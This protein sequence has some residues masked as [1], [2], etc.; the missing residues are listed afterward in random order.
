MK[1]I[2]KQIVSTLQQLTQFV[3][4]A[5][6]SYEQAAK[7]TQ[8]PPLQRLYRL[9]LSQRAEF[10]SELNQIIQ[11]HHGAVETGT[12]DNSSLY[13]QW[14]DFKADC[15]T[16][17]ETSLIDLNLFGEEWA[18]KAYREALEKDGLPQAIRQILERQRQACQQAYEQLL[19]LKAASSTAPK[20]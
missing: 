7:E 5:Q 16:G 12:T 9:L 10:A 13:R 18:Q 11:S 3:N 2:D 8:A 1:N 19:Q 6:V 20:A 17:K 15:H 14:L 4:D